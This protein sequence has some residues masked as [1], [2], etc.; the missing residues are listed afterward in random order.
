MVLWCR[1]FARL[2]PCLSWC[3]RAAGCMAVLNTIVCTTMSIYER[4]GGQAAVTAPGAALAPPPQQAAASA[5]GHRLRS[6]TVL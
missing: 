1:A 6:R 2:F 3:L 5:P 4:S